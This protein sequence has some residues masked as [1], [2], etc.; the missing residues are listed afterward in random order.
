MTEENNE[1]ARIDLGVEDFLRPAGRSQ[2]DFVA[3][4]L[5][6]R[7]K[8]VVVS[9]GARPRK[10][11]PTLVRRPNAAQ[12]NYAGRPVNRVLLEEFTASASL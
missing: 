7:E 4:L 6:D 8:I 12:F 3:N 5:A 9:V 11:P 2:S 1:G 10:R